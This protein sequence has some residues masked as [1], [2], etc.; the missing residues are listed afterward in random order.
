MLAGGGVI[1]YP[2]DVNR[3]NPILQD[4]LLVISFIRD[5]LQ[6]NAPPPHFLMFLRCPWPSWTLLERVA[7]KLPRL[8]NFKL[9]LIPIK[10]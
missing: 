7:L 1:V 10:A 9:Q 8:A 2:F 3:I 5:F 6:T 4:N